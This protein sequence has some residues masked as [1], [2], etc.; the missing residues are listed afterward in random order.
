MS[1]SLRR[2]SFAALLAVALLAPAGAA[3]QTPTELPVGEAKGVRLVVQHG[4]LVLVFSE[5]SARL[6]RQINSRYARLSCTNLGKWTNSAFSGNLDVPRRGRRVP[7]GFARDGADY[8]RIFLRAHKVKL[9]GSTLRVDRDLLVSIP[10]TQPGA[11]Y[12]DEEAAT[13]EMLW[14][15][16]LFAATRRKLKLSAQPTYAQIVEAFPHAGRVVS[17]LAAPGDAPP[18]NRVG[19]YSDGR[20]HTAL[21]V[22][23]TL[24]KRLYIENSAG[25]VFSTNVLAHVFDNEAF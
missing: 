19:L 20:E 10:I 8:C 1:S 6:R 22:L 15:S 25:N 24:G 17:P 3:A 12:L 23:S 18:P 4:G 9:R 16:V 11:V 14:A 13:A 21:A 2:W 7:T 5:R